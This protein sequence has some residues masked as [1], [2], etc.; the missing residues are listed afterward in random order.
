MAERLKAAVLKTADR[1]VRG[2]ESLSLR[3]RCRISFP[4]MKPGVLFICLGNSCRSIMAEAL[5]RHL[6]GDGLS[7]ASAGLQP[8]GFVAPETLH[9]LEEAGVPTAGLRSKG[10]GAVN[11]ENYQLIVN[12][13]DYS[14]ATFLP[15][16]CW[17]L[18]LNRPVLDPYGGSLALYRQSRGAV[19]RLILAEIAPLC[20]DL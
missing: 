11:L 13:S 16:P 10:L 17:P 3:Q 12:L 9:V 18:V 4:L 2:F 15:A 6:L 20:A 19:K 1:K 7:A 5:A 14:L 8:L